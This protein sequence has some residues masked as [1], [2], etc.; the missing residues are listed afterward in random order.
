MSVAKASQF[1]L[2]AEAE[3]LN[4]QL[5]MIGLVALLLL[6]GLIGNV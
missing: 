2:N 1:G 4:G 3:R 5:S 6:E